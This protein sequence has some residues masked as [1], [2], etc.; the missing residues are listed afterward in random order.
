MQLSVIR[1]PPGDLHA[2]CSKLS[3]QHYSYECTYNGQIGNR[4][5]LVFFVST[6]SVSIQKQLLNICL[7]KTGFDILLH[8]SGNHGDS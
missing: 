1:V 6:N 4:R 2:S 7:P 8:F 3:C 5:G